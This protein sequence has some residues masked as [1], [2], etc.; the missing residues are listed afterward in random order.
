MTMSRG[1]V[2]AVA[3]VAACGGSDGDGDADG[4]P[5]GDGGADGPP[6]GPL[7]DF[8]LLAPDGFAELVPSRTVDVAWSVTPAP[9]G[10]Q[11]DAL[12]RDGRPWMLDRRSLEPGSLAWDGEDPAGEP[13]PPGHYTVRATAL[14]PDDGEAGTFDGGVAHLIVVQGVRFRDQ[15]LVYTGADAQRPLVLT[16]VARSPFELSLFLDRDIGVPD[17]ELPL[18]DDDVPGELVPV[19]RTYGFSGRTRDGA[20]V[21]AGEY[22]LYARVIARQGT[23]VYR[24]NGPTLD[25][26]P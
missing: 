1:C 6:V 2:L 15:A 19:E 25:W 3:L 22:V 4:G 14:G 9:Y 26:T 23:V 20:P 8:R 10:L 18:L 7:A 21:P 5:P 11:L 24:V 16:T 17:D 13:A 12:D